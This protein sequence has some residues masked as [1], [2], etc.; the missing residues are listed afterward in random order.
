MLNFLAIIPARGASKGIP[1]K[2]IKK[3]AGHPLISYTINEAKKAKYLTKI[4]VSTEDEKIAKISKKYRVDV[5]HRPKKLANDKTPSELVCQH[6]IRHLKNKEG[7]ETDVAVI[8][9]PTSPLRKAEDINS[10]IRKFLR[11]DCSSVVSITKVQHSP[12]WM[13]K[14]DKSKMKK[15]LTDKK[16]TR[17]QDSPAIYQLNGAIYV[18]KKETIMEKNSLIGENMAGYIMPYER[19]IDID[20]Q[21]DFDLAELLINKKIN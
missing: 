11:S 9:Q 3:M 6:V 21:T 7:F 16:I 14:I 20:S 8:L 4:V 17:R 2:N 13:Y 10:A 5:I 12:Y 19:S 1:R 18:T 15:I